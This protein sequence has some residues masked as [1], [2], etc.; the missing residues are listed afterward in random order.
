MYF[1]FFTILKTDCCAQVL[2]TCVNYEGQAYEK[3]KGNKERQEFSLLQ[4]VEVMGT[5]DS[6]TSSPVD[7]RSWMPL[8]CN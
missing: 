7:S 5:L 8:W 2:N 4:K 3:P 1:V 6:G